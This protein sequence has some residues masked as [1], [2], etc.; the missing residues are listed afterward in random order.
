MAP[1]FLTTPPVSGHCTNPLVGLRPEDMRRERVGV[2]LASIAPASDWPLVCIYNGRPLS[3]LT[4]EQRLHVGAL[5]EAGGDAQGQLRAYALEAVGWHAQRTRPGD[6]IHWVEQPQGAVARIILG[7][8]I[9]AVGIFSVEYG[10]VGVAQFGVSLI[11]GGVYNLLVAPR[12]SS[13]AAAAAAL[14]VYSDSL[15]GNAARLD[16]P[17]WKVCGRVKITPPFAANPYTEFRASNPALPTVNCDQ[18]YYAIFALSEGSNAEEKAFIGLTQIGHFQDIIR[19]QYLPPGTQPSTALANVYTSAEISSSQLN[20]GDYVGG[21][22]ACRPTDQAVSIGID[23]GADQGLGTT[24]NHGDLIQITVDWEVQVREIDDYGT[25][26]G[27]WQTI[28]TETR[29][30][31]TNT[32]QRWTG[33]YTLA[34]PI[35][36]EVRVARTNAQDTDSFARDS[37]QWIGLRA[38]LAA[39][40]PLNA[41]VAHYEVVMRSS[42]Q[43]S[44]LS[45]RDFSIILRANVPTL[46]S[47]L[48]RQ[49]ASFSRN[50]AWWLL[51]LW[52]NA[53]WGEGLPDSRIDLQSIYDWAQDL[54]A[55]QDRFDYCFANAVDSW[56]AAQTIARAGRARC[57]RRNG[58]YTVAR[59]ELETLPVTAITP[60]ISQPKSMLLHAVL[61]KR[62]QP[63]GFVVQFQSN[64]T[65]DTAT[66]ECPCPGVTI[67]DV[68][69]PR[70]NASL[71]MMANPV[72]MTLDGVTGATHA[73]R[74]GLYQAA[75]LAYRA[76]TV[77]A[78]VEMEGVI[79]SF[80]DL[81]RWQPQIAGYGQ[82]GDVAFW[83]SSTLVMGLSEIPDF[84]A[85]APYLTLVRDDGTLTAPVQVLPGPTPNDVTLPALPDFSLVIDDGLRERPKFLLGPLTTGDEFAKVASLSDGGKTSDGA[86]LYKVMALIDD[87]RVHAIDNSLLPGPGDVQ[88]PV[89]DGVT[90]SNIDY[91][92]VVNIDARSNGGTTYACGVKI[93]GLNPDWVLSFSL[94]SGQLYSGWSPWASDGD[95][96]VT[97]A[98]LPWGNKF[99]VT[100]DLLVGSDSYGAN[101]IAANGPAADA[102]FSGGT[103]T[104]STSYTFWIDDSNPGDNRGGLSILVVKDT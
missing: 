26:V 11:M 86:Q 92:I 50:P 23:I 38:Y 25:P 83:N 28:A 16:Q 104:G 30:T 36:C 70:Y 41:N 94:P 12:A 85:G 62:E 75:S 64:V 98:G 42:E 45:Q 18:Y 37:I 27:N 82:A 5:E 63:D 55:R 73:L 69:D 15:A 57:F 100:T 17:I 29:T 33:R 19:Q 48:V 49:T 6:V 14:G 46:N 91:S 4:L 31:N 102:L 77:E 22:A 56:E 68:E 66:L 101:S 20:P 1:A 21:Y 79:M 96:N 76:T 97:N 51:D 47:S 58:V 88:D 35:R 32:P 87:A 90:S 10:G 8:I 39:P 59:D 61:P 3:R 67:T 24:D 60:R 71:P 7:F 52:T 65:W 9:T 78:S 43:L 13:S 89:D 53:I 95:P 72:Y 84:S 74:E 99:Q 2:T 93:S 80:M 81:V 103:I 44:S 40:A 34:A 54:D